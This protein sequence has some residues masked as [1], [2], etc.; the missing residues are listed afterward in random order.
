MLLNNLQFRKLMISLSKIKNWSA[1]IEKEITLN[2]KRLDQYRVDK[3]TKK[4]IY[5]IDTPPPYV[6]SPIHIA[7]AVTYCYMDFF[8][9]YK[10]M[11]GFDVVF[12]LGLDRNGLPIE[13]AAEKKYNISP[14]KVKRQEFI[15]KCKELINEGSDQTTQSFAD[16]GISF[17]SYKEG[18]HIGAIYKTDSPEYRKLTQSTF[19]ELFKKGLV[20]EDLRINNWDPKL[21]TT[22][23]DSEIEYN[24]IPS[25]FND[26]IWRIKE[27][28]KEV[29]ISTTRPELICTCAMVIYHPS[30]KRYKNLEG[31]KIISPIF[32]KEIPIKAHPL[33]DPE[34]GSGLVMMCSAGDLLD[35][36]FFREQNLKPIIAIEKDGLM[37]SNAGFL[38]GL[39]VREA[40][41]KILER[42]KK[43]NLLKNQEQISHRTPISERSKAEVEFI[44]MPEFYLRQLEFKEEIRKISKG[45]KFYPEESRKILESW[46][47]SISIDWPISRRRF[48]AT[49]IP[50]WHSKN[51]TALPPPGKYYIPWKNDPPKDSLVYENA[52]P[53]GKKVLDYPSRKWRGETRVFDTW[54]DSSISELFMLQYKKRD[55]FFE[56]S[57][58]AS[59]RPQG[60][61]IVRTWLYYTILRGYLQTKK[62]CFESVWIH[63]HL[64][65][66]KGKK[67]AKSIGNV[68]DPKDLVKEYGAEAIR[69]WASTEGNLSNNDLKV[70]K[71]RIQAETKTLNKI[72]NVSKFVF[73]F[74][75]PK[76]KPKTIRN[77]D[78]VFIEY[79]DFLTK[80]ADESFSKYDFYN[81]M[82]KLREFLWETFASHYI[83]L[84][85][86][87]A[88]NQE[89]K[90]SKEDSLSARYT[91]YYLLER[92][93]HLSFPVIPQITS[94]IADSKGINLLKASFPKVSKVKSNQDII[95]KI[96]N[97]NS[98]VWKTKKENKIS[99]RNPIKK[100]KIPK[101]LKDFESD[102]II[103]HNLK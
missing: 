24:E 72:L 44:E 57:Y 41:K 80:L 91:L 50:L 88:Y 34:K 81:P 49:P 76:Q 14:F 13:M 23:A 84:V 53:T 46:I 25:T 73:L 35:I 5:S 69:I 60:K 86:S 78:K 64:T 8:A 47:D 58:P 102:L 48:Y 31:K 62:A 2:W 21:Q 32:K 93:L 85:K 90:F 98:L 79:I 16:L 28:N 97:F 9:R 95:E 54:M 6:N 96:K 71:Q 42:L 36:Q 100:I 87:R 74:E 1:D 33:A 45:I 51:L 43:E 18:N 67:M 101:E 4:K 29:I 75:K 66:D 3:N 38:N 10:R 99:L 37:N 15:K 63:Q 59:L 20:Y 7:Q 103:C 22:I 52:K 77:L 83:E 40:R 17:T 56:K 89:N 30:D 82:V 92:F 39:K 61:E 11:K 27:T 65:D 94:F 70:S 12:P 19:I 26:I 68:I 55:S